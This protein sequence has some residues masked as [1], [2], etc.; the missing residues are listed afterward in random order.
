MKNHYW[1]V[2]KENDPNIHAYLFIGDSFCLYKCQVNNT[3]KPS[4]TF[5][6]VAA[7]LI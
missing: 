4:F 6:C 7:Q 1:E 3:T 2:K 5:L